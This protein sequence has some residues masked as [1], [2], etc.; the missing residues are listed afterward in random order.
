M[1]ARPIIA[2][3]D[4]SS[5]GNPGP[6]GWGAVVV[7]PDDQVVELGGA[8]AYTTNNRMEMMAAIEVLVQIQHSAGPAELR[9][10]S[11]YVINGITKWVHAWRKR[12]WRTVDGNDVSNRDLWE[13][14]ARLSGER[15]ISNRVTWRHVRGHAGEPGNERVD[16]IATGFAA[17]RPPD[18]YT[19]GLDAYFVPILS[20]APADESRPSP[21]SKSRS[22]AKAYSYLSLVGGELKRHATWAECESRVKGTSGAKFKKAISAAD[23]AAILRSWGLDPDSCVR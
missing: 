13:T 22:S 14:L 12:G 9:T 3:A 5:L 7:T 21:R 2:Y 17:G 10:D 20:E 1:S 8:A 6:G 23:E 15:G 19:G 11:A 18:L 4:G 16:A